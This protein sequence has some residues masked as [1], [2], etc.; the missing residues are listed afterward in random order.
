MCKLATIPGVHR[1]DTSEAFAMGKMTITFGVIC[2]IAGIG[3]A[4]FSRTHIALLYRLVV[5]GEQLQLKRGMKIELLKLGVF[6]FM[7]FFHY[8]ILSLYPLLFYYLMTIYGR[9]IDGISESSQTGKQLLNL[10]LM[11]SYYQKNLF[12]WS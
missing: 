5:A 11:S 1:L 10:F 4:V 3:L 12:Q 2:A 7:H 6:S 9:A 8:L